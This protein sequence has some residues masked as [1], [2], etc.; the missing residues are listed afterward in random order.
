MIGIKS[1]SG[2]KT[3]PQASTS[4]RLAHASGFRALCSEARMRLVLPKIV[5]FYILRP[6]AVLAQLVE[7]LICNQAVSGSSP[8]DGSIYE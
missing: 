4:S 5:C 8:L 3:L 6:Q 2:M 7:H 1:K